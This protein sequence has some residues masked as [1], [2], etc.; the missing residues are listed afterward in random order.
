MSSGN[1]ND[2]KAAIPLLKGIGQLPLLIHHFMMDAGYDY[3]AIYQQVHRMEAHAI[4]AKT[5]E[6]KENWLALI[7]I[8]LP[9]VCV[10]IP[11]DMTAMMQSTKHLSLIDQKS[12]RTVH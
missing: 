3:A 12:V 5:S 6:T 9:L 7:S 2:G 10:N 1:L 4:I 8:L 11:I